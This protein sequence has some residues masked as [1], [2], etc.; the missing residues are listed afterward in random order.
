MEGRLEEWKNGRMED[1]IRVL[2]I[3][4]GFLPNY[5]PWF[6]LFAHS[7][8]KRIRKMNASLKALNNT[9]RRKPHHFILPIS[10]SSILPLFHYFTIPIF[11]S[12]NLLPCRHDTKMP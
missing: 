11:Q 6:S 7:F 5:G 9:I 2:G 3:Y 4:R 8:S 10:Q 12:S 1:W